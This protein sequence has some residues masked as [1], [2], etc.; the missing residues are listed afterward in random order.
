MF[1]HIED[2]DQSVQALSLS[3]IRIFTGR[4]LNSQGC[5]VSSCGHGKFSLDAMVYLSLR[6]AHMPEGM[7]SH[8][9]THLYIKV[10]LH[11]HT[12]KTLLQ[13]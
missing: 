9:D 3:L 4:I 12:W 10:S 7:F 5:Q 13:H 11:V 2:S 8:T 1:A 6:W